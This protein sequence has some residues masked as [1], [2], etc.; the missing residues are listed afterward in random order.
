MHQIIQNLPT[1]L[2]FVFI[3]LPEWDHLTE[4]KAEGLSTGDG[5][6]KMPCE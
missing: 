1:K 4:N 5:V 6:S 3:W 2:L